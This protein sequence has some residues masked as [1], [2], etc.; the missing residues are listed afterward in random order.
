MTI[1]MDVR[2]CMKV[3]LIAI[4]ILSV[5]TWLSH[6]YSCIKIFLES[7][8]SV[9]SAVIAPKCLFIFT[10]IIVV[11]LVS[12]SKL[13]RRR[14][15]LQKTGDDAAARDEDTLQDSQKQE[16]HLLTEILLPMII[17]ES[18]Q[19]QENK[20]AMEEKNAPVGSEDVQMLIVVDEERET[21]LVNGAVRENKFEEK[22]DQL[23]PH[24][25]D[26]VQE[27]VEEGGD[28][29]PADELNRRVEDF[30]ARFNMERQLEEA[31]MLVCCY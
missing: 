23:V 11:F 31:R 24:D 28:L 17:G 30:I 15:K 21:S 6:M 29:P 19:E 3:T 10:N 27:E 26:E 16:E 8:P 25:V 4:I 1:V 2:S 13:S 7:L 12:E 5:V 14:S 18:K 20:M 9:V 22:V